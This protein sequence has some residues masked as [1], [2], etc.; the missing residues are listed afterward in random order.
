MNGYR[1]MSHHVTPQKDWGREHDTPPTNTPH[2]GMGCTTPH[3]QGECGGTTTLYPHN[4]PPH[5]KGGW[6]DTTPHPQLC[7]PPE[8]RQRFLVLLVF[9]VFLIF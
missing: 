4:N 9:F 5:H 2:G 8:G 7:P 6:G 3:P 1:Y